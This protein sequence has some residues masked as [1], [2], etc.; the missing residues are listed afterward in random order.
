MELTDFPIG[1]AWLGVEFA[2]VGAVLCALALRMLRK[3]TLSPRLAGALSGL[4]AAVLFVGAYDLL[5]QRGT[6]P[7]TLPATFSW[8]CGALGPLAGAFSVGR[9][10]AA[11]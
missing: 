7:T 4:V 1:Y 3:S 2:V 9:R 11:V 8:A 6:A 5:L 10:N